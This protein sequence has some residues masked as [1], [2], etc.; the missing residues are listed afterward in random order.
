[1]VQI[2]GLRLF[3][4]IG[5]LMNGVSVVE[6]TG[7]GAPRDGLFNVR[8]TLGGAIRISAR[9]GPA[10]GTIAGGRI[11]RVK[12]IDV[13]VGRESITGGVMNGIG[14]IGGAG[15]TATGL[16]INGQACIGRYD[17][18]FVSERFG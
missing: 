15:L 4:L 17:W 1:M 9:T 8:T 14:L 18:V 11:T 7:A 6:D 16:L 3:R 2:L 5:A 13:A 10:G 12:A